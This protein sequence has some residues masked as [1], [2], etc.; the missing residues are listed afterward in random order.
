MLFKQWY[1]NVAFKNYFEAILSVACTHPAEQ[2]SSERLRNN[3]VEEVMSFM[4]FLKMK[5]G[6]FQR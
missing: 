4:N 5:Q 2:E 6:Q 3:F 1:L